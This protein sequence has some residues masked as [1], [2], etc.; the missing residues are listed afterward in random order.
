MKIPDYQKSKKILRHILMNK[1][2][3]GLFSKNEE[4]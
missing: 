1:S 2:V 3:N 4:K